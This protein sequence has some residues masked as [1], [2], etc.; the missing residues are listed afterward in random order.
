MITPINN[1]ADLLI[2]PRTGG[3]PDEAAAKRPA[4]ART[5]LDS[6]H[7]VSQPTERTVFDRSTLNQAA[8]IVSEVLRSMDTHVELQIDQ[9]SDQVVVK[10]LK[11]SGEVIRQFPP[12]ELLELAKY[13]SQEGKLPTDKGVLVEGRV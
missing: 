7:D 2:T 10:V 4:A 3:E 12:K 1:K 6:H 5:Q 9:E 13:L 8:A 11:D